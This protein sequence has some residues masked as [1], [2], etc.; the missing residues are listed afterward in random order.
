MFLR[1]AQA[2]GWYWG[3]GCK[4]KQ[5]TKKASDGFEE[6]VWK[7]IIEQRRK[8]GRSSRKLIRVKAKRIFDT[9]IDDSKRKETFAANVNIIQCSYHFNKSWN[10]YLG[11]F[12]ASFLTEFH[13][14]INP[15][16]VTIL[17]TMEETLVKW[18]GQVS[19]PK[20]FPC[21]HPSSPV[22]VTPPRAVFG[23]PNGLRP[24]IYS[25]AIHHVP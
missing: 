16:A 23:A 14:I 1:M 13:R 25:Y 21:L 17:S 15:L 6:Q 9:K 20:C 24:L 4:N 3:N 5:I 2:D 12:S 7:W 22:N 19:C 11:M 18:G 8:G 10:V